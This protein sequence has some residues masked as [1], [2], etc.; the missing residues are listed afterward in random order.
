MDRFIERFMDRVVALMVI[1]GALSVIVVSL[2]GAAV[3][4]FL[5][6]RFMVGAGA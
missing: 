4:V 1:V 2:A 5:A 6:V 3:A